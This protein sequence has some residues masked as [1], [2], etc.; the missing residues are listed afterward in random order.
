MLAFTGKNPPLPKRK[1][2]HL[3]SPFCLTRSS[4]ADSEER[5]SQ[6]VESEA[7]YRFFT[8][9]QKFTLHPR[10]L[11]VHVLYKNGPFLK[12]KVIFQSHYVSGSKWLF[13]FFL[14]VFGRSWF[15]FVFFWGSVVRLLR[16]I[17][18]NEYLSTLKEK[19]VAKGGDLAEPFSEADGL[20]LLALGRV[21]SIY[22]N[23]PKPTK[24]PP[25]KKTSKQKKTQ[26]KNNPK[27]SILARLNVR[28][29]SFPPDPS[30][31][32]RRGNRHHQGGER[33]RRSYV[34]GN[35]TCMYEASIEKCATSTRGPKRLMVKRW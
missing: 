21:A 24:H 29:I 3:F 5:K 26:Q 19:V 1:Y 16:Y 22:L 34:V 30:N 13:V 35:A 6:P 18:W 31:I 9:K 10:K 7:S 15:G 20:T 14:R 27:I 2:P 28:H 11:T 12:R 33:Q 8:G 23:N 4:Y 25:Q 17:Q 32:W